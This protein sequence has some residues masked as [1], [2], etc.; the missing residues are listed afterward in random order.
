MTFLFLAQVD[1]TLTG[2]LQASI[3]NILYYNCIFMSAAASILKIQQTFL[4][5][6]GSVE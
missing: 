3:R 4:L 6:K 2:A 1:E 5:N